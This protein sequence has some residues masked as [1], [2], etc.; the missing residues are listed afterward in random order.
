MVNGFDFISKEMNYFGVNQLIG[1]FGNGVEFWIKSN[2]LYIRNDYHFLYFK[3]I[4]MILVFIFL[5]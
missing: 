4:A 5:K 3:F 2:C 1:L